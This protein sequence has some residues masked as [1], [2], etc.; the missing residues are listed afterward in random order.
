MQEP[1]GLLKKLRIAAIKEEVKDFK[2]FVF[3]EGHN[4]HYKAGQYLTLVHRHNGEELRR[5]YSITSSPVLQ[6]P[7]AIGV[8]RI[9]NGFFSRRLV[10]Q[11]QPG[12]ELWTT[13]SG[14][15]FILPEAIAQ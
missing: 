4:I 1:D 10:D 15:F 9:E 6:E 5:S 2:T 12:D 3:E 13:G 8:K 14:G 7:L 11:A